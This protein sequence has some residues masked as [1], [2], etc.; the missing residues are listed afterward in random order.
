MDEIQE[1]FG[2]GDP[3]TDIR[4]EARLLA[5]GALVECGGDVRSAQRLLDGEVR[6]TLCEGVFIEH[7]D[8]CECECEGGDTP[9]VADAL[10]MAQNMLSRDSDVRELVAAICRFN[11]LGLAR[12]A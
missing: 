10:N 8:Y 5:I 1:V 3:M 6:K 12:A 7:A 2:K 4:R 11:S 9:N